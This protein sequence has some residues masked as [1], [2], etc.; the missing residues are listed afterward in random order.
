MT[1]SYSYFSKLDIKALLICGGLRFFQDGTQV[2][3]NECYILDKYSSRLFAT[4]SKK[5]GYAASLIT[6]EN[7]LWVTGGAEYE[8]FEYDDI[9][10]STEYILENGESIEGPNLPISLAAHSVVGINST[11]SMFIGGFI[12]GGKSIDLTHYYD[13]YNQVW[14]D[15]PKLNF[16]R[17]FHGSGIV[18]DLIT[19]ERLLVVTGGVSYD[20]DYN[21]QDY[22]STEI[23]IDGIW[24]LG[25]K[26]AKIFT[27]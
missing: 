25:N 24:V 11:L 15:G 7:N 14:F 13:N 4:M 21:G 1:C 8:D 5:R 16:P 23:L 9:F 10:S 19:R 27:L 12:S 17:S 6:N 2:T 3:S 26:N 18:T 20:N 22:I